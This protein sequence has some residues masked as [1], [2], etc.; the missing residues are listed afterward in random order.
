MASSSLS[1]PNSYTNSSSGTLYARGICRIIGVACIIGFLLDVIVLSFPPNFGELAWRMGFMQQI[2][3]RSIILLFGFGLMMASALDT[4]GLR[5]QIATA[6]LILGI[7]LPLSS[8]LVIRDAVTFQTIAVNN[9]STQLEQANKRLQEVQPGADPKIKVTQEQLQQV[10][11]QLTK[12]A[13]TAQQNAKTASIKTGLS[14]V[15]N[16]L[17]VGLAMIGVGRYGMRRS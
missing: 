9:I 11:Q 4:R 13:E 7:I 5:K 15:G 6:C 3:D 8:V 1:T 16:L 17:V 10:A 14:G 12:S 2:S